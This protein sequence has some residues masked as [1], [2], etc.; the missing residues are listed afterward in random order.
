MPRPSIAFF[1][2]NAP[3][4]E[5]LTS[6]L[7]GRL[8]LQ[9]CS[10]YDDMRELLADGKTECLVA[11][12]EQPSGGG[13]AEVRM[14]E[15]LQ[16]QFPETDIV[17]LTSADCPEPLE[18]RATCTGITH[19][20]DVD[21]GQLAGLLETHCV[22]SDEPLSTEAPPQA[23]E[24]I[25]PPSASATI[26]ERF[27]THSAKLQTML[28]EL[29]VAARHDVIILLIG[30]T[31]SGKTFLSRQIHEVSPRSDKPF[32]HVACGALPRELIE[33]ELFGHV[34]GAFT[35]AHADKEGKFV[36]AGSGTILLDEI[37][38]LGPEQQMKLLRVIET[39]EFEPVG[40]NQT[41]C[42]QARLVVA[43]NRELESL[44]EQ[45][46]FRPDL[47]YRLN[48][49]KFELPPLRERMADVKSLVQQ[50][51]AQFAAK[52]GSSVEHI[53]A[54]L[55]DALA[56]YPWPGN[57][58][59]LENVIQ[60]AVIYAKDGVLSA[61][62]LPKSI[63]LGAV[64]PSEVDAEVGGSGQSEEQD[65]SLC[66]RMADTERELIE[67]ALRRNNFSRTRTARDL[68]VSR[69]TLYN[70]MKKYGMSG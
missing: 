15:A 35:S 38:A 43:S 32:L 52:H 18:R 59:E 49:L 25:H 60:R 54:S 47:Y 34:K 14:L 37:D 26:V 24:P 8:S 64:G 16:S 39:G 53:D 36:A 41:L 61:A 19:L 1:S 21:A 17:M 55:Y 65:D 3:L 23:E 31:G 45:G 12:F 13:H 9:T 30:E 7:A 70:K 20:R 28:E 42:S 29:D 40:S 69:V 11:D 50:F 51:V 6:R 56:R 62:Q 46:R 4:A 63:L 2:Q 27:A 66:A 22:S 58:R 5:Q 44:V 33:S 68:G 57:V 48:M 10:S 67:Q